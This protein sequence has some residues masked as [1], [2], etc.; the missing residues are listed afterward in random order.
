MIDFF[1]YFILFRQGCILYIQ[2]WSKS[3]HT[4]YV[5]IYLI[6]NSCDRKL[7]YRHH[8]RKTIAIKRWKV[9]SVT[10]LKTRQ[11]NHIRGDD[12]TSYLFEIRNISEK[13]SLIMKINSA[14]A[15]KSEHSLDEAIEE[16]SKYSNHVDECEI[17]FRHPING[18][19]F[20]LFIKEIGRYQVMLIILSGFSVMSGS[21]E[22]L[23]IGYVMPYA[24]CDLNLTPS[25]QGVLASVSYL[26]IVS[27]SYF[28]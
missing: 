9:K 15:V 2:V 24:K 17:E 27:T 22:N 11:F 18:N 7:I 5:P 8:K 3:F 4:L 13:N 28:W 12:S 6:R 1:F 26:G 16:A 20:S 10:K 19:I 21:L 23:S 25:E 14:N